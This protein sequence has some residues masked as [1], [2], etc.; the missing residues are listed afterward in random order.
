MDC[1]N[2]AKGWGR[3]RLGWILA[4]VCQVFLAACQGESEEAGV[5]R[6]GAAVADITPT[7]PV[8]LMGQF[9][10]RITQRVETPLRAVALALE[11]ASGSAC[12]GRL[13]WIACDLTVLPDSVIQRFRARFQGRVA[14]LEGRQVVLSATHTH[15]APVLSEDFKEML[16]RYPLP[17]DTALL[18]P[19]GYVE[20]LVERLCQVAEEA[21][22]RRE[23]AGVSWTLGFAAVGENRRA[24]FSAGETRMYGNTAEPG[25]RRLEGGIDS[26]VE[27]LFFWD[28]RMRLL[29]A[30]VNVSCPAQ[31]VEERNAIHAD[32][33]H[34]TRERIRAGV[35]QSDLP[36]LGWCGAAGDISPHP[37]LRRAAEARM[38][39]LRGLSR[40]QELGRRIAGAVLDTV[41]VA[42]SDTRWRLPLV[43]RVE[44]V[45]VPRR[46]IQPE[47]NAAAK[48]ALLEYAKVRE[49][50]ARIRALMGLE[51]SVVERFEAGDA[52]PYVAEV[53]LVRLG[54]VALVSNPFELFSEYGL[55]LKARSPAL[56]TFVV[57]LSSGYGMY[58]PTPAAVRGGGYSGRPHVTRVGPEG[59]Q[60]LVD[61]SL[62]TL[63]RLFRR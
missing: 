61:A 19:A 52:H 31:E 46:A 24:N 7:R 10:T 56:Q 63:E 22:A 12:E 48:K 1:V 45:R 62:A 5:L 25:F 50:D 38:N 3:G 9:H 43:H 57:Q 37:M 8:A 4:W 33:W 13:V 40:E 16:I 39:R 20:F 6:V 59:G 47:E 60:Q 55:Q 15:T 14:G 32:F 53:H 41:E 51:R 49:P 11:S 35:G 28:A 2:R 17:E 29:A 54:D 21:W 23:P 27:T 18:R 58:L 44:E 42:R 36:V 26:G 30:A 34:E